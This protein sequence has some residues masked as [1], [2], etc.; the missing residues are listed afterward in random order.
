MA[1]IDREISI[2]TLGKESSPEV[3]EL[4]KIIQEAEDKLKKIRTDCS[5]IESEL[6]FVSNKKDSSLLSLRK[7]CTKCG[8]MVGYPTADEVENLSK[9]K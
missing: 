9:R 6:S 7:I 3:T 4:L 5:H 8:E 2:P 1:K